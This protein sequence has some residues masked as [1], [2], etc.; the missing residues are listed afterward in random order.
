MVRDNFVIENVKEECTSSH[1]KFWHNW[2]SE[3][4]L[5]STFKW[6]T[7]CFSKFD[8]FKIAMK[9]GSLYTLLIR[10]IIVFLELL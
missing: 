8:S 9:Q 3:N 2:N 5:S 1:D 10:K 7:I 4:K 6:L